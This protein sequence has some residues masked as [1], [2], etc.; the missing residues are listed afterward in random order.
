MI[1]MFKEAGWKNCT[2]CDCETDRTMLV[3]PSTAAHVIGAF[4]VEKARADA[5]AEQAAKR[6]KFFGLINL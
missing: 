5:Q 2:C 3:S 1:C 6:S 4:D